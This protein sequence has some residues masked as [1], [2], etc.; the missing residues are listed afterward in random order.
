MR[1]PVAVGN[2]E[3]VAGYWLPVGIVTDRLR[4]KIILNKEPKN[5]KRDGAAESRA[6]SLELAAEG[7]HLGWGW[8]ESRCRSTEHKIYFAYLYDWMNCRSDGLLIE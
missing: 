6:T 7:C 1:L 4:L 2:C 5:H 3:P 8:E